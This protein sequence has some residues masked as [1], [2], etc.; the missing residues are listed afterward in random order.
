VSE[1]RDSIEDI[2][3]PRTPQPYTGT[4]AVAVQG[5]AQWNAA[6]LVSTDGNRWSRPG[7]P[8]IYLA[9]DPATALAELARHLPV[10]EAVRQACV[11]T[12]RLSLNRLVDLRS[13]DPCWIIHKERCRDVA[14]DLR[15][16]GVEGLIVPS[17]AFLDRPDHA[18]FVLFADQ[19]GDLDKIVRQPRRVLAIRPSD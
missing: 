19:I 4:A 12:I 10:G 17:V 15:R 13:E 18:N 11:W 8:T 9:A 1:T 16:R 5:D 7:E 14:S 3:G 2:W 6:G